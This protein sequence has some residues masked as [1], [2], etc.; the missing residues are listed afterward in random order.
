MIHL[1]ENKLSELN[2]LCQ[3]YHVQRLELFGS[4]VEEGKFQTDSSDLDCL[5]EFFH[6]D[7]M[8]KADQYFDFLEDWQELFSMKIDLVTAR[9]FKNP[10][11]IASVNPQKEL[12][13]VA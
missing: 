7:T 5:V 6:S 1:I 4:A 8:N 3:R 2:E 9:A 10:Y 11:F 12:L 13:Y